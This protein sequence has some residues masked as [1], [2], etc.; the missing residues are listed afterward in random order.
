MNDSVVVDYHYTLNSKPQ[1]IETLKQ[2]FV[3][4]M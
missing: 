1:T 4:I 3:V 2:L